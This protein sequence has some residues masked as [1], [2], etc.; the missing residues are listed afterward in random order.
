MWYDWSLG[1]YTAPHQG[2]L[3]SLLGACCLYIIH[4]CIHTYMVDITAICYNLLLLNIVYANIP[5]FIAQNDWLSMFPKHWLSV[6]VLLFYMYSRFRVSKNTLQCF[7]L[8]EQCVYFKYRHTGKV[9]IHKF[10]GLTSLRRA[11]TSASEWTTR[12]SAEIGCSTSSIL[13]S[14][15]P[16][17]NAPETHERWSHFFMG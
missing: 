7:Y 8:I 1:T 17:S 11:Q 4:I 10:I 6:C 12:R 2:I 14:A 3:G 13:P 15:S 5:A 9:N 16:F